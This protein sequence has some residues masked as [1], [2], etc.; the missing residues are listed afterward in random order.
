MTKKVKSAQV[1]TNRKLSR[2]KENV[3]GV[4]VGEGEAE[5]EAEVGGGEEAEVEG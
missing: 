3:V 1:C 5:Q 2:G 4:G